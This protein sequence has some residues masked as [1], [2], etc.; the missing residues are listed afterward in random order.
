MLSGLDRF[1]LNHVWVWTCKQPQNISNREAC[2]VA[3][4]D[5]FYKDNQSWFLSKG[6]PLPTIHHSCQVAFL[7][8]K[9][10][11]TLQSLQCRSIQGIPLCGNVHENW[12]GSIL[13]SATS[14]LLSCDSQTRLHHMPGIRFSLLGWKKYV[15]PHYEL[16]WLAVIIHHFK[17]RCHIS[18]MA[19]IWLYLNI[20]VPKGTK[21]VANISFIGSSIF[22]NQSFSGQQHPKIIFL[23]VFFSRSSIALKGTHP[24]HLLK[25][26]LPRWKTPH[27]GT[28][29]QNHFSLAL[30]QSNTWRNAQRHEPFVN[31]GITT[32]ANIY[33]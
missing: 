8:V 20:T 32:I 6:L 31:I 13:C 19:Y 14:H 2:H 5:F 12:R 22:G 17:I 30:H 25:L 18:C 11:K 23:M 21:N 27:P 26:W 29:W 4:L 24:S 33:K 9:T 3:W 28:V 16:T 10:P 1:P 7:F 15:H